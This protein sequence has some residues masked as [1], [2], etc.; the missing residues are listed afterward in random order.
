MPSVL[1]HF[2]PII[3]YLYIQW[4][5]IISTRKVNILNGMYVEILHISI[6]K[7]VNS[8]LSHFL[9]W[10]LNH[11]HKTRF[12]SFQHRVCTAILEILK[13]KLVSLFSI[14]FFLF[15]GNPPHGY[16]AEHSCLFLFTFLKNIYVKTK[17]NI[18]FSK[19]AVRLEPDTTYNDGFI[20]STI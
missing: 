11:K 17:S 5:K 9:L 12:F 13:K 16:L 1:W 18:Y 6:I 4:Q 15:G 2:V 19:C 14:Y 8:D 3:Y 10:K 7:Q 20:V